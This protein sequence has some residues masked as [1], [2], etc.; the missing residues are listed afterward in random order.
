MQSFAKAR[1][2]G[3]GRPVTPQNGQPSSDRQADAANARVKTKNGLPVQITTGVPARSFPNAQNSSAPMQP[4]PQR[5]VSGQAQGHVIKR[6]PFDTDAESID[7]TV[8]QSVVQVED[9]QKRSQ[10]H[11]QNEQVVGFGSD[12][13]EERS[14]YEEEEYE[15][16]DGYVFTQD[17]DE[18]LRQ[19]GLFHL[20]YNDKLNFLQQAMRNHG[21]RNQ[22][23]PT[24]DGDSYPD[25]TNGEPSELGGG[26]EA[27][28]DF[29]NDAGLVS[30][31]PR[32]PNI[33]SQPARSI[34]PQL[35]QQQQQ[36]PKMPLPNAGMQKQPSLFQQ[37]AGYRDQT[38]STA[39]QPQYGGQHF[40]HQAPAQPFS[41]PPTYS[42]ANPLIAPALA[43]HP[44]TH[45]NTHGQISKS[46]QH[47]SRQPFGPS[48]TVQFQNS[49]TRP[50]EQQAPLKR[51][52][53]AR[54]K[55]EPVL[56]QQ[57]I[58]QAPIE[59]V[60]AGPD[61]DYDQDTL[62]KKKYQDLKNED[63]D[64]DP[65]AKPPVLLKEDLEKPL[66]E[67]LE[68][69]QKGLDAGQQSDFFCS[70]PTAEWEDAGDWFLDQFQNI[71]QRT[72]Q[73]RQSKRKLAQEFENEV[74]KRHKHVSKKRHQVEQAMDKMKAQGQGLVP[75]S[76]R[77]SKSP[78]SKRA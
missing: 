37:A 76:P 6:D 19:N 17:D 7:T 61:G 78:R 34:A 33:I 25:T 24:I 41:Q 28:S 49:V 65:R 60:Q 23:L 30:P 72:K 71:I 51:M 31:S 38:R 16:F 74:E 77:P 44:N 26:Q 53:S 47:V 69:V 62:F 58:E 42:Q 70:L 11:Q 35:Q 3:G 55:P 68:L 27:P 57:P 43:S 50:V 5:R 13:E 32:R 64:T 39:P 54:A 20:S 2:G 18:Y 12:G 67:R 52:S 45:S 40:Q 36:Q 14:E 56:Q 59:E 22:G 1:G 4:G 29:H 75:R 9:S 8:N 21:S 15:D 73:A 46:S 48:R 63:L 10:Q 66:V